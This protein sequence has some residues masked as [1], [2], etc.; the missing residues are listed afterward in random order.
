MGENMKNF[1]VL[2]CLMLL[3][4]GGGSSISPNPTDP[5][6]NSSTLLPGS[7]NSFQPLDIDD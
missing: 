3:S 1:I 4:C 7:V 5:L 6:E 2:I